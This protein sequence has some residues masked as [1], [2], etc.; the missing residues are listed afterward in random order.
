MK[1]ISSEWVGPD[2]VI[3]KILIMIEFFTNV[4]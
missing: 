2:V 4:V 3:V 1:N